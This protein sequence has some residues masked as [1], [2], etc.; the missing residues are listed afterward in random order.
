M[1]NN[2]Q[3]PHGISDLDEWEKDLLDRLDGEHLPE[4]RLR[5]MNT[6]FK[7]AAVDALDRMPLT[8]EALQWRRI[9]VLGNIV[10]ARDEALLA[11]SKVY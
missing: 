1:L 5:A 7:S 11:V 9:K 2:R 3:L 6:I 4:P 10:D 8:P